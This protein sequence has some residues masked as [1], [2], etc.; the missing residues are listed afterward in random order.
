M[1]P[2]RWQ[3][4]DR[5]FHSVLEM[6]LSDR[7]DFLQ[8]A[9]GDDEFLRSEVESLIESHEQSDGFITAPPGEIAAEVLGNAQR[10]LSPRQ[11]VGHYTITA[12]LATGGMGEVYLARDEKLGRKIA[13]KLLPA[14]FTNH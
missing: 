5:L 8:H 7:A 13:L 10:R 12:L 1:T 3:Q 11:M 2:E 4:I 14:E 9:C 6:P